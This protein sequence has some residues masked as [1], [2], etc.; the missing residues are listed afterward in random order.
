MHLQREVKHFAGVAA[1]V[2]N[3]P[4]IDQDLIAK[5]I[6]AVGLV[7]V[8]IGVFYDE[9]VRVQDGMFIV[10]GVGLLAYSIYLRDPIFTPLQIVFIFASLWNMWKARHVKKT[11]SA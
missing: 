5:L 2:Y 1:A 4:M 8:S 6:G 7:C 10:G 3:I 9:N 11:G